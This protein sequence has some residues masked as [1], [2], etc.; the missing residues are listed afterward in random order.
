MFEAETGMALS[1][2]VG[3]HAGP[4]IAGV[5][6]RDRLSYDMWGET[7]N[8]ASRLESS[9]V[10]GRIHV[11]SSDG[12]RLRNAFKLEPRGPIALKGF[13]DVETCFVSPLRSA[14]PRN[15]A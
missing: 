14:G 11:A 2:R 9:G 5:I 12:E 8:L 15:A 1:I 4:A 10:P 13:G 7:V 6:G 3:L